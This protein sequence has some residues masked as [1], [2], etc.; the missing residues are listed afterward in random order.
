MGGGIQMSSLREK[1][2]LEDT[3]HDSNPWHRVQTSWNGAPLSP[4][5]TLHPVTDSSILPPNKQL[6]FSVGN[7]ETE[8]SFVAPSDVF[9]EVLLLAADRPCPGRLGRGAQPRTPTGAITPGPPRVLPRQAQ[10]G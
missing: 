2:Q 4:V 5:L 10:E 8:K 9:P 6:L 3:N 7:T 1:K